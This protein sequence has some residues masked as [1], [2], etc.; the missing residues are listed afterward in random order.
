[1]YNFYRV[2]AAVPTI[3]LAD[4]IYN[5]KQIIDLINTAE[6]YKVQILLFSELTITGYSC[7]DLFKQVALLEN[8]EK[9]LCYILDETKNTD[10]LVA[11]GTPILYKSKI[12]NC[13]V[14]I[15]AGEIL[16]IVKKSNLTLDEKRFF[17]DEK[18]LEFNI[19]YCN[20]DTK[21]L[22]NPIFTD[23]N[24]FTFS[25]NYSNDNIHLNNSN[26]VLCPDATYSSVMKKNTVELEAKLFTQ[27]NKN[28]TIY[29]NAGFGEST[30]DFVFDGKSLISENGTLKVVGNQFHLESSLIYADVDLDLKSYTSY[31]SYLENETVMVEIREDNNNALNPIINSNPFL[32]ANKT[33]REEF[34]SQILDIQKLGLLKRFTHTNSEKLLIGISGGLDSTLALLVSVFVADMLHVPRTNILGIS[35]PGFGTSKRTYEN[36]KKLMDLLKIS[37]KEISIVPACEQHFKD[38]NHN[39][40]KHDV[41]FENSQ[42]RERTQILLDIANMENGL[43]V[44][45]G[46]FTELALGFATYNGDHMSSYCVNGNIPKNIVKEL[47]KNICKTN[48]FNQEIN[49]ILIDITKTNISPELLPTDK[50]GDI[51]QITESVVGPYELNDFY[52]YYVLKHAYSP[53]KII[54]MAESAFLYKYTK[55]ELIDHLSKF[56]KRFI[57][58]QF[59]RSCLPDGPQVFDFSLSPRNGYLMPSDAC[60]NI[61]LDELKNIK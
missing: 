33:E 31:N 6:S 8:A 9:S 50:N 25:L 17:S 52:L 59:K 44:G 1:M 28:C 56:Y 32:P 41:T 11:L 24:G 51:S 60:F 36:A 16:C 48:I 18:N 53:K 4:T 30:T 55:V 20:Q 35:M 42:A 45:T 15:K 5:A 38:I 43:V 21:F 14:F 3:K 26:I 54:F 19:N 37:T 57:T 12:F 27:K 29:A 2:G 22:E 47:I 10:V 13:T 49:D 46:D 23:Q 61:W 7:Q 58:Q 34:F 40:D 39:I